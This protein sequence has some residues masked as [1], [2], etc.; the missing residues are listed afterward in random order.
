MAR[1]RSLHPGFFTDER[2]VS[3]SVQSRLLFLGLGVEADDKG[4]FE[5]KPVTLKM[6][7]F[8]ADNFDIAELLSELEGA[9]VLQSYEMVGRKFGAIRNFRRHQRPKTP[10]SIHPIT[11]DISRYVGLDVS[12]S[13]ATEDEPA[14]FP[15][16]GEKPP[17]MEDGGDKMKEKGEK[18]ETSPKARPPR[19]TRI[20]DDFQPDIEA[21]VAEGLT[22]A[23]AERQALSF[24]DYFRSKPGSGAVKLDWPATWR[25]WF[26]RELESPRP[27]ATSPPS[28]RHRRNYADVAIEKLENGR[29][30]GHGTTNVFGLGGHA[31]QLPA[32]GFQPRSDAENV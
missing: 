12:V 29:M 32:A 8:P 26:R 14:P 21:A 28:S 7:L 23:V 5:W 2:L 4:V 1:I 9:G 11:P 20:P 16:K 18:E 6:R 3:V 15:P 10:N 17:Q 22:R 30:N 19:G 31:Q 24:T 13:E 25:V 27:N